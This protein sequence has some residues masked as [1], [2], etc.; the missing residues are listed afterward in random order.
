MITVQI[1]T[2]R[3]SLGNGESI[4]SQVGCPQQQILGQK[5][6][7]KSNFQG[8]GEERQKRNGGRKRGREEAG[9]KG[10]KRNGGGREKKKTPWCIN[11]NLGHEGWERRKEETR[12][13]MEHLCARQVRQKGRDQSISGWLS[14]L[15]VVTP[16]SDSR[17]DDIETMRFKLHFHYYCFPISIQ[18]QLL[19]Y[20]NLFR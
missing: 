15:F 11:E 19:Q 8:S 7:C 1:I 3:F 9:K 16:A 12:G 10:K 4:V 14:T 20:K 17:H 13:W 5:F 2:G 6:K 18:F